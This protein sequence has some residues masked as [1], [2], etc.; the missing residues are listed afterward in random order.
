LEAGQSHAGIVIARRRLPGDLA[1]RIGRTLS[2]LTVEDLK[3]QLF[4]V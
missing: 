1:A 3:N 2:Q 4:Y